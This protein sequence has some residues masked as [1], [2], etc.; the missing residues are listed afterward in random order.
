MRHRR[1]HVLSLKRGKLPL[2][3]DVVHFRREYR[4][5]RVRVF[6][7]LL[8]FQNENDGVFPNVLLLW[9]HGNVLFRIRLDVRRGWV[10]RGE[11]V[12]SKN[13]PEH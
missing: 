12:R 2:A 1:R 5:L 4:V 9:V 13:L 6:H 7:I 11:R 10:L 8:H 3:L